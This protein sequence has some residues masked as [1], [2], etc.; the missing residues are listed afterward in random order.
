MDPRSPSEPRRG[1]SATAR[2][3][4]SGAD[5]GEN[6]LPVRVVRSRK[7]RRTVSARVVDGV[8]VIQ[9][10]STMTAADEARYVDELRRKLERKV[11]TAHV[12]LA[13]RARILATRFGLPK[14]SAIKWVSNQ[15]HRWGSCSP[16][17]KEIRISDRL[18]RVPPWVLDYV[19]VHELA[20]LRQADHGPKFWALVD[21]YPQGERAKGFL[22]GYA[23]AVGFAPDDSGDTVDDLDGGQD[24]DRSDQD[25]DGSG[26]DLDDDPRV[27]NGPGDV[28]HASNAASGEFDGRRGG[29]GQSCESPACQGA[30]SATPARTPAGRRR[31]GHAGQGRDD[32]A[33][34]LF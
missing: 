34:R 5:V 11:F 8:A 25:L 20:H 28:G 21:Q 31:K 30:S 14:P 24:L 10:P 12:D 22:D 1:V 17:T 26:L 19:I 4:E 27:D 3:V 29:F 16:A 23:H 15:E 6:R 2:R 33:G 13:D 7:R 9:V 18:N 32:S